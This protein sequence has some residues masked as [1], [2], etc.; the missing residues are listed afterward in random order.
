MQRELEARCFGENLNRIMA[1]PATHARLR[2]RGFD[3][4]RSLAEH[5]DREHELLCGAVPDWDR[6]KRR[7]SGGEQH[8]QRSRT[9]RKKNVRGDFFLRNPEG[10]QGETI[11]L[12]DDIVTSGA[13][14][15]ECAV[16]LKLAG[17]ERVV[18][19]AAAVTRFA[20]LHYSS[21]DLL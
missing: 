8:L 11:L 18:V 19:L 3:Q 14:A 2:E 13:T 17:A 7:V 1:V 21:K 12:V 9:S 20:P 4:A 5:L 16:Q 10:L 6:L 15:S